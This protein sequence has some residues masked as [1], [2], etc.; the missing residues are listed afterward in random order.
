MDRKVTELD[1]IE[2]IPA[3]LKPIEKEELPLKPEK[4]KLNC[5]CC[6]SHD[7]AIKMIVKFDILSGILLVPLT[8]A[9]AANR[10]MSNVEYFERY[11][12]LRL[13]S[14]VIEIISFLA[15]LLLI[16]NIV[17]L[18]K[19]SKNRSFVAI[20]ILTLA[21]IIFFIVEFHL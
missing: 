4:K 5:L 8:K 17:A 19:W 12:Q 7:R 13:Y 18:K 9:Y 20:G 16:V 15:L 14:I 21:C 2:K 6:I 3:I 10:F 11:L 1:I